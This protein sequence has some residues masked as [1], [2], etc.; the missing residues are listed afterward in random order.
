MVQKNLFECCHGCGREVYRNEL[1]FRA[2]LVDG[3]VYFHKGCYLYY[4]E[5]RGDILTN[6]LKYEPKK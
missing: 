2:K 3:T 1:H 4:V 6:V 5:Q